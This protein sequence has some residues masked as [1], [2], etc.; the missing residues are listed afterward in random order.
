MNAFFDKKNRLIGIAEADCYQNKNIN[1]IN[2]LELIDI[3]SIYSENKNIKNVSFAIIIINI[4]II[5]GIIIFCILLYFKNKKHKK[6]FINKKLIIRYDILVN[7]IDIVQN[8]VSY[9]K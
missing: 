8:N 2:G 9:H 7:N 6:V 5:C 3:K 4:I 1:K